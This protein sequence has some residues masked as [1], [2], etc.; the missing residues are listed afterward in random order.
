MNPFSKEHLGD[1]CSAEHLLRNAGLNKHVYLLPNPFPV[2]SEA[3]V[4]IVVIDAI[5]VPC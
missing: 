1:L 4:I 3:A 2:S 5:A